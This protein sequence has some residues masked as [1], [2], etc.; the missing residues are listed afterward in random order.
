MSKDAYI[1]AHEAL[2]AARM[3]RTG[4][5]WTT[6][7]EGTADAAWD[8]MREDYADKIDAAKEMWR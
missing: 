3:D 1:A 2:I 5:D 6:A 7:Y 4:C 8:R